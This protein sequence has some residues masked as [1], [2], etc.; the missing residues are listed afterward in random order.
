MPIPMTQETKLWR[1][2]SEHA[3]L[4]RRKAQALI[5]A[6]EVEVD[7]AI[8]REPF[9]AL[10]VATI[11]TLRLRGHP[12]CLIGPEH[13]VY[14]Y[15]KPQGVLCSHDDPHTGNTLGRILRAE[16]FIGYTWAGRLDADVEGLVLLTN[17]GALVNR[18]THPRYG[19]DKT[20]EV[21]VTSLPSPRRMTQILEAM[22]RGI[23]DD[24]ETL[25][26]TSGR[27]NGRPPRVVVTLA[28]GRK[29]EV[30]RLFLRSGLT[31]ARLRRVS[32]GPV[33]LGRL[34][35]GVIARLDLE[36]TERLRHACG[37]RS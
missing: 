36:E 6:G 9:L 25:R 7:G 14:R 26:V 37:S 15:H 34:A 13:R 5:D 4:S 35:P 21:F 20:Y 29:H 33:R 2:V 11:D 22:R 12:I 32:I 8:V 24:G 10:D 17:D 19:V 16:G 30:K 23:T 31:V 3:G 28:E 27:V 18:L 1:L